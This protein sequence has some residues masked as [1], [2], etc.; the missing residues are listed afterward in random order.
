VPLLIRLKKNPYV[1][2][3]TG[4]TISMIFSFSISIGYAVEMYFDDLYI[5]VIG[6]VVMI[7]SI[8]GTFLGDVILNK[9]KRPSIMLFMIV[10][11]LIAIAITVSAQVWFRKFGN[12]TAPNTRYKFGSF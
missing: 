9:I 12:G 1:A 8:I 2:S 4:I 6:M 7:A 10:F 11:H 5:V 3:S